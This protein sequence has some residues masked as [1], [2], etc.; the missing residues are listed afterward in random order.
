[1]V[2]DS[3]EIPFM[4]SKNGTGLAASVEGLDLRRE[5]NIP[6]FKKLHKTWMEYP[7]LIFR[8]Q[9]ITDQQQISF[10]RQFGELEIHPSIA[11]RSSVHPEIYRVANVDEFGKIMPASSTNWQYIE[12]TWH[13]HTDSSFRKIPSM[14]SI[15]HGIQIPDNGGDTLFADMT[16]AF[17]ALPMKRRMELERFYVTHDHDHILSLSEGLA[18]KINKGQYENLAPVTHPLIRTHPIT[19]RRSLFLSPHTMSKVQGLNHA[20]GQEFLKTLIAHAT[21]DCFVY[22]H[23]WKR[24]DVIMWDNRCTMHA[25]MPYDAAKKR[26]IM[27]RTTIVG[28]DPPT[29]L[30]V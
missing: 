6:T 23:K 19:R 29:L 15:L 9:G 11:H 14:G 22:R 18:A 30:S 16:A 8:D 1:M 2:N 28:D 21:Q 10:A 17:D 24:N 5:L 12:L 27:H 13:W 4:V 3:I 7:V 25:V 26:R 20:E